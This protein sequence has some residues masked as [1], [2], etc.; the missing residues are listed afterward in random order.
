ML[1][2]PLL[3]NNDHWLKVNNLSAS[4]NLF[5]TRGQRALLERTV[6]GKK[7]HPARTPICY[8]S[9]GDAKTAGPPLHLG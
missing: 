2:C 8:A 6:E 1:R 3:K 7:I 4:K 5:R 9:P